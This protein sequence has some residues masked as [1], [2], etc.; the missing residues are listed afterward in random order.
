[1][2]MEFGDATLKALPYNDRIAAT[3]LLSLLTPNET[4]VGHG[5]AGR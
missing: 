2:K 4:T 1:M 3:V 5:V